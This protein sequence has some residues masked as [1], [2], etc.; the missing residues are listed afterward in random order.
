[1]QDLR[2]PAVIPG[3]LCYPRPRHLSWHRAPETPA[4]EVAARSCSTSSFCVATGV[5]EKDLQ[6]IAWN[7]STGWLSLDLAIVTIVRHLAALRGVCGSWSGL[8]CRNN[9]CQDWVINFLDW[10]SSSSVSAGEGIS[11]FRI[12]KAGAQRSVVQA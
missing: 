2:H 8:G 5:I 10:T 1:M 9:A 12:G 11:F 6:K 4:S 3:W 7:Y